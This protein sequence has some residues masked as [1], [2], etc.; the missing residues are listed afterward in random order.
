MPF[1]A[2]RQAN[3][4]FAC[5]LLTSCVIQTISSSKVLVVAPKLFRCGEEERILISAFGINSRI[6]FQ[7]LLEHSTH[8]NV[9]SDQKI[10]VSEDQ[11][12]MANLTVTLGD[13][14]HRMSSS[15]DVGEESHFVNLVIT[16]DIFRQT[17][18]IPVELN[19]GFIFIQTDKPIYNPS[20]T[21]KIRIVSLNEHMLPAKSPITFSIQNPRGLI[22][23]SHQFKVIRPFVNTTYE[24]TAH[25]PLG[26]WTITAGFANGMMTR[27]KTKFVVQK[28]MLPV[29]EVKIQVK[30]QFIVRSTQIVTVTTTAKYL[31]GK[32]VKGKVKLCYS[33]GLLALLKREIFQELVDGQIVTN[34]RLPPNQVPLGTPLNVTAEVVETNSGISE[35]KEDTSAKFVFSPYKFDVSDSQTF[36]KPGLPYT[37]NVETL[38]ANGSSA[39]NIPFYLEYIAK[40]RSNRQ[41]HFKQLYKTITDFKQCVIQTSRFWTQFTITLTTADQRL[42]STDQIQE[43]WLVSASKS[44]TDSYLL[45]S[46]NTTSDG[47][48]VGDFVTMQA[49]TSRI[50]FKTKLYYMII[51]KSKILKYGV[52]PYNRDGWRINFRVTGDMIPVGRVIAYYARRKEVV[53]D[54][55]SFKVVDICGSPELQLATSPKR[56]LHHPMTNVEIQLKGSP[57]ATVGLSAVDKAVYLINDKNRLTRKL[58]KDTMKLGDLA[59]SPGGGLNVG[60][61]FYDAGFRII[62]E[63]LSRTP[64][65]ESNNML[66]SLRKLPAEVTFGRYKRGSDF[67]CMSGELNRGSNCK[68]AWLQF[69]YRKTEACRIAFMQCCKQDAVMPPTDRVITEGPVEKPDVGHV[70]IARSRQ[71]DNSISPVFSLYFPESELFQEFDLNQ[72]GQHNLNFTLPDSLTT[73]HIQGLSLS[74]KSPF[75]VSKPISVTTFKDV[76]TK[77]NF[78]HVVKRLEQI[79]IKAVV[80]NYRTYP[81]NVKVHFHETKGICSH[82]APQK[83]FTVKLNILAQDIGVAKLVIVPLRAGNFTIHI[84]VYEVE[85][86]TLEIIEKVLHVKYE[87]VKKRKS[88]SLMLDP[89]GI[90]SRHTRIRRHLFTDVTIPKNEISISQRTQRI[91]MNLTQPAEAIEGS[92]KGDI[93]ITGNIL[94][95]TIQT[96]LKEPQ[97]LLEKPYGCGEQTMIHLAPC[98]YILSYLNSTKQGSAEIYENAT[99]YIR[100]GVLREQ[101]FRK[102][103]GSYAAFDQNPS[104]VWLT[105][106]VLKVFCQASEY[107]HIDSHLTKSAMTWLFQQQ[108]LDGSF[109]EDNPVIHQEMV[110]GVGDKGMTAFVLIS[111]MECGYRM[112]PEEI[113]RRKNEVNLAIRHIE[114]QMEMTD[115][116][117]DMAIISYALA[118]SESSKKYEA[119]RKLRSMAV[120]NY[121]KNYL[122]WKVDAF[123][124]MTDEKVSA[125][126]HKE[127]SYLSVEATAYALLT[128]LHY[129]EV[130]S[131]GPI[132]K[133]LIE[134][135]NSAG[136]FKSTQDTVMALQALAEYGIKTI[137]PDINL[138]FNLTSSRAHLHKHLEV[139]KETSLWSH[140]IS[141]V[142]INDEVL[143]ES[144]GIG[145][146]QMEL[147]MWY[148]R[149]PTAREV[150]HFNITHVITPV[151]KETR[152]LIKRG[153]P[154]CGE[155]CPKMNGPILR[156]WNVNGQTICMKIYLRYLGAS[157]SGMVVL[158]MD[159]LTGY[160][161]HEEL[162]DQ[163]K[164]DRVIAKHYKHDNSKLTLYFNQVP[165]DRELE[166]KLLLFRSV[167]TT[168]R[169]MP[170][171]IHVFVYYNATESCTKFYQLSREKDLINLLCDSD[172]TICKCAQRECVACY[173][174]VSQLL[175]INLSFLERKACIKDQIVMIVNMTSSFDDTG[176]AHGFVLHDLSKTNFQELENHHAIFQRG[177][178]Y[179]P[180]V[181][182]G[183]IYL[184]MSNKRVRTMNEFNQFK[185]KF[186]VDSSGLMIK[187]SHE[188]IKKHTDIFESKAKRISRKDFCG[189]F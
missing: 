185:H 174:S 81:I 169:L 96:T 40:T 43:K 32:P 123:S 66:C 158:D 75:C 107:E 10:Y 127:E 116:S 18:E 9:I 103:D 138:F 33:Y 37:V 125:W 108:R 90:Y 167:S 109:V 112:H 72:S 144:M 86:N 179:C 146:A 17:T 19:T 172:K 45:L 2:S 182:V 22:L 94:G 157:N 181:N 95:S 23:Y 34:I 148:Y 136:M 162:L 97:K 188:F 20:Q 100:L 55:R 124:N 16:S 145:S 120:E 92:A 118:L 177:M 119:H 160:D 150:C 53:A 76:I 7:V 132:V 114:N 3:I 178:C 155:S 101:E 85:S 88:L 41:E 26:N 99:R 12:G 51:G 154:L 84:E 184:V 82:A 183:E 105:A 83:P 168:N 47:F 79:H 60:Q 117:Y 180:R 11:P 175:E 5:F 49:S 27:T 137:T 1:L 173:E 156:N 170:A 161:L 159:I 67:C 115:N 57:H 152:R 24:L 89:S 164:Q 171:P 140:V 93:V 70:P 4:I 165:N 69:T 128:E 54:S 8:G 25:P 139:N 121:G 77:L 163:L 30:P 122:Y 106:F 29:F 44:E 46:L 130:E 59:C 13:L 189:H 14:A 143:I 110:G 142:P 15:S 104:S 73:W 98:V 68:I 50:F 64:V 39:S 187:K 61:V 87:G 6:P 141:D 38:Y 31:Y 35:T 58:V 65:A 134:Q 149:P 78:P 80:Y 133:W 48:T 52:L 176:T 74:D 42:D 21:V 28:Y 62:T 91:I 147:N 186:W 131:A 135:R 126:Y 71:Q 111:L 113:Y 36:F 151:R 102:R 153:C 166:I 129:G 56:P 63:G